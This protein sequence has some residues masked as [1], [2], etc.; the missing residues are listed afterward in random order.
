[1]LGNICVQKSASRDTNVGQYSCSKKCFEEHDVFYVA[2]LGLLAAVLGLASKL[3]LRAVLGSV[4]LLEGLM[5]DGVVA[6]LE[7]GDGPIRK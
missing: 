7:G 4:D 2:L 3:V 5:P 1:M 6:L